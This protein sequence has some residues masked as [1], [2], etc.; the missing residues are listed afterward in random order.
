MHITAN[1]SPDLGDDEFFSELL[2]AGWFPS[3]MQDIG[4]QE[5]SLLVGIARSDLLVEKN[6]IW[7]GA[8]NKLRCPISVYFGDADDTVSDIRGASVTD[9]ASVTSSS[10]N[11]NILRGEH[12]FIREQDSAEIV[13]SE[14][15][16]PSL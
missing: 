8:N 5:K 16:L 10:F 14:T 1:V 2:Q 12:L 11:L 7:Y 15:V 6:Y 3:E 4:P 13:I 9:W